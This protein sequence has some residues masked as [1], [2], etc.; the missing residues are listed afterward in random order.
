MVYQPN[1]TWQQE[2]WIKVNTFHT[3]TTIKDNLLPWLRNADFWLEEHL[4][5]FNMT[6]TVR[7]GFILQ[8]CLTKDLRQTLQ[9]EINSKISGSALIPKTHNNLVPKIRLRTAQDIPHRHGKSSKLTATCL[10]VECA[11]NERQLVDKVLTHLSTNNAPHFGLYLPYVLTSSCTYSNTLQQMIDS[12]NCTVEQ[13]P[14]SHPETPDT[15]ISLT[16]LSFLQQATRTTSTTNS[17]SNGPP[18][19]G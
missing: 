9:D 10:A 3:F 2:L 6:K 13:L 14:A 4:H 8:K 17:W 16:Y 18:K 11:A 12:H 19:I 7:A 1:A 5:S 15:T